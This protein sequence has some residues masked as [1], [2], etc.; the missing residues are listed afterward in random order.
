MS[1][2]SEKSMS[3]Q[4]QRYSIY[5]D[6]HLEAKFVRK[7]VFNDKSNIYNISIWLNGAAIKTWSRGFE[8]ISRSKMTFYRKLENIQMSVIK[9]YS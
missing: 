3:H 1:E 7:N 6:N 2:N 4:Q 9:L 5:N 8:Y